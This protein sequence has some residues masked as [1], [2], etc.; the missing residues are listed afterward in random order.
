MLSAPV[1]YIRRHHVALLALFVALGGTSL[2]A[3]NAL[4]P[5]NSVGPK[6][7]RNGAVTATKLSKGAVTGAKV[8]DNSLTGADVVESSLGTVP[9]ASHAAPTG[10]AGGALAGSYP[11]PTIAGAPAPTSVSANPVTGTDP[12]A[13]ATPQTGIF[14]GTSAAYWRAGAY[15][16]PGVQ[17]W[18]DQLGEVHIRGEADYTTTV[19]T[20]V[21]FYLPPGLRPAVIHAFPVTTGPTAGA[22]A[23]GSGLLIVYPDD[24]AVA[25]YD[26]G[27]PATSS[28]FIGEVEFRT[29][30]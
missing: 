28:V 18:R 21:I 25:L 14:C 30:A 24:G 29:D 4:L 13:S 22:F 10:T 27:Y 11:S 2:A 7:L 23:A 17:F 19:D 1:T 9:S 8:K 16:A 5:K 3:G 26:A 12:C 20:A 15:A 6:Q